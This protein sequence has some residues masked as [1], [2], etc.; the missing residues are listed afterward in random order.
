MVYKHFMVFNLTISRYCEELLAM[1]YRSL[2]L[3][4]SSIK[5]ALSIF[6]MLVWDIAALCY[7]CLWLLFG[8]ELKVLF[9][10]NSPQPLEN[11]ASN[12]G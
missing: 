2:L 6:L 12:K 9:H 7:S 4:T 1:C 10:Q 5:C 11:W 8:L 3:I